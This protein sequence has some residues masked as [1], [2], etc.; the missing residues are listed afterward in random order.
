MRAY[1]TNVIDAENPERGND[2]FATNFYNHDP[3]PGEQPGIAGVEAFIGS[4]FSAFSGFRTN[5][6]EQLAA[7]DLVVG[8]WTQT[9]KQ[10]GSYL[11]FPVS[12]VQVLI[13][14]ITITRVRNNRIIEEWEARDAAGLLH[15]MGV[16]PELRLEGGDGMPQATDVVNRYFY[17]IW[18]AGNL[19]L[20]D[21]VVAPGFV[22]H[23]RLDGQRPG[24]DGVKQLLQRFGIA[25]PDAS[26]SVDLMVAEGDRVATRYTMRGTHRD[27]FLGIAATGK[28]VEFTGI[29]IF[30]VADGQL[31]E[32]WGYLD[33]A[34]LLM[35]LGALKVPTP[36]QPYAG[37][38]PAQGDGWS[39]PGQ[40][41][42]SSPPG[43]DWSAAPPPS[44][45]PPVA[46]P[47]P[48]SPEDVARRWFDAVNRGDD[49]A[50]GQLVAPDVVDHSGLSQ[51]HGRGHTGHRGLVRQ[52]RSAL[53]DWRS[54]ITSVTT[55][56]DLVT[57]RHVGRGTPQRGATGLYGDA[58]GAA[59]A[60]V[61]FELVSTVRV[62]NGK[63]VEHWANSGPFGTKGG[64]VA[65]SATPDALVQIARR[66]FDAINRGDVEQLD[67]LV[68]YDVVD[69]SG[70]SGRHG[71]GCHGHKQ[72]IRELRTAIPDWKSQ[73]QGITVDGDTV[74]IRHTGSGTAPPEIAGITG[75]GGGRRG[76]VDFELVSTV[77]IANGKI[78]EHWASKGPFGSKNAS[79]SAA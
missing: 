2:Y 54:E 60:P 36:D 14:G 44:R 7:G 40:P 18:N 42:P 8:R 75:G 77:R 30:R 74:T 5:I 29:T 47:A 25:F 32:G 34:T 48:G 67:A 61:D 23:I 4:I 45:P 58:A 11:G 55:D 39:Q 26:V 68:D 28:R 27:G 1:V 38:P 64:V 59:A 72:L 21:Q 78:V 16:A 35:Q 69:H 46:P 56:G 53:P 65:P 76:R 43:G 49:A 52:L 41:P 6:N 66:W 24:R 15:Q 63:I 62:R 19:D 73:I 22:N 70:L 3:A 17:D 12:G 57:I 31:V 33:L 51:A 50:L 79:A 13:G 9:F 37:G 71:H 20:I 10:T